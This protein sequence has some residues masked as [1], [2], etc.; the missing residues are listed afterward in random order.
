MFDSILVPKYPI[1]CPSLVNPSS[2]SL[3]FLSSSWFLLPISLDFF[4]SPYLPL[5][6]FSPPYS[7][8]QCPPLALPLHC[9][10]VLSLP[11]LKLSAVPCLFFGPNLGFR[12]LALVSLLYLFCIYSA[13]FLHKYF[14]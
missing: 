7:F 2:Y 8:P 12:S 13:V 1:I 10:S 14:L 9:S 3:G 4:S 5:F 11:S 6:S